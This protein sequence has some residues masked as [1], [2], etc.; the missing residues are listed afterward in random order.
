MGA[1]FTHILLTRFNIKFPGL[2][3]KFTHGLDPTWLRHRFDL[4][5]TFCL[6]SVRS[7]TNRNFRWLVLFD[8]ETPEEFRRRFEGHRDFSNMKPVYISEFKL[9]VVQEC[10]LDEVRESDTHVI[11][12]RLDNDDAISSDFIDQVQCRFSAQD[13]LFVNFPRGFELQGGK[14]YERRALSNSFISVIERCDG[15]FLFI[16]SSHLELSHI[17]PIV[18]VET[19]P[20]WMIVC[21]DANICN[22]AQGIRVPASSLGLRFTLSKELGAAESRFAVS[23]DRAMYHLKHSLRKIKRSLVRAVT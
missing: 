13:L 14:L 11:V 10:I 15:R 6:P 2:Q 12:S 22:R 8:E 3:N 5:E 21:H 17:G 16:T 7:Q 1:S 9:P 20:L 4:F 18:N 23:W 19:H